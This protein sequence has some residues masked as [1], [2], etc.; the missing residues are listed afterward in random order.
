MALLKTKL[1]FAQKIKDS[2]LSLSLSLSLPPSL[3]HSL[4]VLNNTVY[5]YSQLS[6]WLFL[7]TNFDWRFF[8]V[9]FYG[10]FESGLNCQ[11]Y[12]KR[13]LLL[14]LKLRE[15]FRKNISSTS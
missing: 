4:T 2:T 10:S 12:K 6:S 3:Q 13:L 7:H 14:F 1:L 8:V 15:P 9:P 11:Q 5:Y